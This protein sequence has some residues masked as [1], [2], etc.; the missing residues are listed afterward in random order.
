[1]PV[2]ETFLNSSFN[3]NIL[4]SDGNIEYFI[5]KL[6]HLLKIFQIDYPDPQLYFHPNPEG[7]LIQSSQIQHKI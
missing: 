4:Q 7:V 6:L 5:Y 2:F 3:F 1:M